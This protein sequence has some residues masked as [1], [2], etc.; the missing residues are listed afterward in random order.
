VF[1][2]IATAD[3]VTD[4]DLCLSARCQCAPVTHDGLYVPERNNIAINC[5]LLA[6]NRKRPLPVWK[7]SIFRTCCTA[8]TDLMDIDFSTITEY[9]RY[10]P[11]ASLIVP[12]SIAL[13]TTVGVN[14]V[15]NAAPFRMFCMLDEEPPIP[16]VSTGSRTAN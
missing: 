11:M 2:K 10:K 15:V 9:Q 14:G 16:M 7:Q 3:F 13:I 4:A 6:L 8:L 12:R 1:G 5:K